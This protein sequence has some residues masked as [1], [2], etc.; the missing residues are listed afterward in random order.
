MSTIESKG[1][2]I[3]SS[4]LACR[5]YTG[6]ACAIK[7]ASR[8]KTRTLPPTPGTTN[9]GACDPFAETHTSERHGGVGSHVYGCD[10]CQEVCPWT[11]KSKSHGTAALD[12][13]RPE[14]INPALEWLASLTPEEF[15]QQFRGS[16]VKRTKRNGLLRNVAI[17]MGNSGLEKFREPL[18]RL[19]GFENPLVA[20]QAGWALQQLESHRIVKV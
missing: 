2:S 6:R 20:E 14:L 15:N 10:I 13:T 18:E 9:S 7:L 1:S 4:P 5:P 11:I 3:P 16:P 17:A 8:V 19:A 12:L